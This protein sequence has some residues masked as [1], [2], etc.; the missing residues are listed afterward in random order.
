MAW[1]IATTADG[2][3]F[4]RIQGQDRERMTGVKMTILAV[5]IDPAVRGASRFWN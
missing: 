1:W 4:H 5:V 3:G 2:S